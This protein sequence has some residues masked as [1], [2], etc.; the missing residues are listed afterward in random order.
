MTFH[1]IDLTPH[2]TEVINGRETYLRLLPYCQLKIKMI[3]N[4]S[5]QLSTGALALAGTVAALS[6]AG[7]AQAAV[8]ASIELRGDATIPLWGT[9]NPVLAPTNVTSVPIATGQ[10]TGVTTANTTIP[11]SLT[12]T[13]TGSGMMTSFTPPTSLPNFT[14][15]TIG[16]GPV[17]ASLTPNVAFGTNA[18]SGGTTTTTYTI[19]GDA[20]FD[21][22]TGPD[23]LGT[24]SLVF[25]RNSG[26]QRYTLTLDKTN[27]PVSAIPEPSSV[28]GILAVAGVGAF[29][30]R[31]S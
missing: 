2:L 11:K 19:S 6:F 30:R 22:P 25:T 31:K 26:G 14:T 15:I 7:A 17:V 3:T 13:G 20:V 16:A 27:T 9:A 24:F 12:L 21:E 4:I 1:P 18:T 28:L 29:S 23:F 10:F 5:R 8:V